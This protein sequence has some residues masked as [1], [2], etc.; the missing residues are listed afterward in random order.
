MAATMKDVMDQLKKDVSPSDS[1]HTPKVFAN[2]RSS[3]RIAAR[4]SL[5]PVLETTRTVGSSSLPK[6]Q[7][8]GSSTDDDETAEPLQKKQKLSSRRPQKRGSSTSKQGSNIK[9]QG[10]DDFV[11]YGLGLEQYERD[12]QST[13]TTR[14][15]SIQGNYQVEQV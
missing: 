6:S 5:L 7:P 15:K 12:F 13:R 14:S 9:E 8:Q 3:I 11:P 10:D 1:I 2:R 4:R